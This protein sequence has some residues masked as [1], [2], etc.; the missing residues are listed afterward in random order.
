MGAV[1][2]ALPAAWFVPPRP[3]AIAAVARNLAIYGAAGMFGTVRQRLLA[4]S[5][6]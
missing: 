3:Y 5:G 2:D 4:A 1:Q 6:G